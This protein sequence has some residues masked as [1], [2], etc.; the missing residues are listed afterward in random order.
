MTKSTDPS[1]KA[2]IS[3][4]M[5]DYRDSFVSALDQLQET[6]K[7]ALEKVKNNPGDVKSQLDLSVATNKLSMG[8]SAFN[9]ALKALKDAIKDTIQTNR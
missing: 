4:S 8:S 9:S 2:E 7:E 5:D 6:V 3:Q 1:S